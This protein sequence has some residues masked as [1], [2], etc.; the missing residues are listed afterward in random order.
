MGGSFWQEG[1]E[2][3]EGHTQREFQTTLALL[4]YSTITLFIKHTLSSL[5]Q[6]HWEG[7]QMRW[8][9]WTLWICTRLLGRLLQEGCHVDAV[10]EP[11]LLPP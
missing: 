7:G 5:W 8:V 6:R 4:W 2:S 9:W 11:S 10:T 1:S 3:R